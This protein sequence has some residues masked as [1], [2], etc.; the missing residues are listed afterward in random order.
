M[1]NI[2]DILGLNLNVKNDRTHV[3]TPEQ[4][5]KVE[6]ARAGL[7]PPDHITLDGGIHRFSTDGNQYKKSG[8]YCG[9]RNGIPC[10]VFGCFKSFVKQVFVADV[11]RDVS[12]A[13]LEES[14]ENIK[15]IQQQREASLVKTQG[16]VSQACK[17]IFYSCDDAPNS[18]PYLANKNIK[19]HEI[20]VTSDGRLVIPL[21]D[22][23]GAFVSIQYI[24]ASGV[25]RF[26]NGGRV[27]S[28]FFVIGSLID[29]EN[30]Y[31]S[32]GYATAASI[33]EHTKS[34]VIVCFSAQNMPKVAEIWRDKLGHEARIIVVADND[35]TGVG[36]KAAKIS[37]EQSGCIMVIPPE[38][39]DA[40]DYIQETGEISFLFPFDEDEQW[41]VSVEEFCKKPEPIKWLIKGWMQENSLMMIHGPSG[42]GKTFIALDWAMTIATDRAEWANY[43]SCTG[44]VIYLAGEGHNGLKGRLS[45]WMQENNKSTAD[46]FISRTAC[47]MDKP[48]GLAKIIRHIKEINKTPKMI[49][50]DTL[51]CFLSGDENLA[52]DARI[53]I[54]S[55]KKLMDEFSCAVLIVHHTGVSEIAKNRARG[56][57]AWKGALEIEVNVSPKTEDKPMQ[58]TQ[59]KSKDADAAKSLTCELLQVDLDGWIDEDGDK[60]TSAILGN[61]DTVDSNGKN[62]L[63]SKVH[64]FVMEFEEAWRKNNC[65]LIHGRPFVSR[66]VMSD[67]LLDKGLK[68]STVKKGLKPSSTNMVI[69]CLIHNEI[70][71]AYQDGWMVTEESQVSAMLLTKYK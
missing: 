8:W 39:G 66:S 16:A 65:E 6:I 21:F 57:S 24:D 70:I 64:G 20:K 71:S 3:Q 13:E 35:E 23:E 37:C 18:H 43:K 61:I 25:K 55:C 22:S 12:A 58:I 51:H 67:L 4:Q 30:V 11:G 27:Q 7:T 62:K 60:C 31:I 42:S 69:G 48:Y 38:I 2:S 19:S 36:E 41:L 9:Y 17:N 10:A 5:L 40:N 33:H 45:A 29:C 1:P 26:H 49:V 15:Q 52:K 56:S 34:P 47:D 44:N 28:C 32:E 68:E 46:M 59:T 53:M 54:D 63:S 14:Q 50:V